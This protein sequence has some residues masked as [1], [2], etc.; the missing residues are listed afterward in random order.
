MNTAVTDRELSMT[1]RNRQGNTRSSWL[2]IISVIVGVFLGTF[3]LVT[4]FRSR[5]TKPP[6]TS[7]LLP[8]MPNKPQPLLRSFNGCAPEG[9]GGD[10][11]LNR[12]KNRVDEG[13]YFAVPF[14]AIEKLEWPKTIEWR[15]RADWSSDDTAAVSRYEGIPVSAE[16]YIAGARQE[17]EESPNCKRTEPAFHDF[18]IWLTRTAGEDRT[19]SIV[20]EM[21][22]GVRAQHRNWTTEVLG[23]IVKDR[24]KVRISGWLL[25]DPEHPDQVGKTRGTIWEIHPVMKFEVEQNGRWVGLDD[26]S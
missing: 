4:Y 24:L 21:T 13:Q 12:L 8:E 17:G 25:L 23:R 1:Y 19:Q 2:T 3:L 9:T 26:L 14:E 15:H 16:G 6:V 22:P 18:H 5:S 20:V 10:P 7:S 11:A